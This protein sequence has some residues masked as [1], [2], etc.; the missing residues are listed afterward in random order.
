MANKQFDFHEIKT[1]EDACNR[2][3]ISAS[4]LLVDS[5]GDTEALLQANAF[6]KLKIIQ[7]AINGEEFSDKNMRRFYPYW[8]LYTAEEIEQHTQA[9]EQRGGIRL[10]ASYSKN[11]YVGISKAGSIE[12]H[13]VGKILNK[14]CC[15][16]F[17]FKSLESALYAAQQF[18]NLFFQY[19]G[20]KVKA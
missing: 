13:Y 2:L 15:H 14:D 8:K 7:K 5:L 4:S 1:F 6:Y 20:I 11:L 17:C 19:Y 3:E 16:S 18:E 9:Y 12:G 10:I